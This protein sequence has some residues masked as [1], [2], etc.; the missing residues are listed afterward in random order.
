MSEP[1]LF[2]FLEI[3]RVAFFT[4]AKGGGASEDLSSY[5]CGMTL[6]G[7]LDKDTYRRSSIAQSSA[8]RRRRRRRVVSSLFAL[9]PNTLERLIPSS[10]PVASRGRKKKGRALRPTNRPRH[11]RVGICPVCSFHRAR[12]AGIAGLQF[13][14]RTSA[15][16]QCETFGVVLPSRQAKTLGGKVFPS[17]QRGES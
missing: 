2:F 17:R 8:R 15:K 16:R 6:L 3:Q 10:P 4:C 7:G 14:V 5:T 11:R 1:L 13:R 12:G 9:A